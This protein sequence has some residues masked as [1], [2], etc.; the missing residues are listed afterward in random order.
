MSNK[1]LEGFD[2]IEEEIPQAPKK[3]LNK[4]G[5]I[6]I[7]V[8]L[9]LLLGSVA[10]VAIIK[11]RNNTDQVASAYE[12][13]DSSANIG[14]DLTASAQT[15]LTE[16]AVRELEAVTEDT[17]NRIE[18]TRDDY[19][20]QIET[21]A[22]DY[23]EDITALKDQYGQDSESYQNALEALHEDYTQQ[24][25]YVRESANDDF[26]G[27]RDEYNR[28]LED[29]ASSQ[30]K[31][32]SDLQSELDE[33]N[34]AYQEALGALD[35]TTTEANDRLAELTAQNAA[36]IQTLE[37]QNAALQEEIQEMLRRMTSYLTEDMTPF[38]SKVNKNGATI[39]GYTE[40]NGQMRINLSSTQGTL[41]FDDTVTVTGYVVRELDNL[42]VG[43]YRIEYGNGQKGYIKDDDVSEFMVINENPPYNVIIKNDETPIFS[44]YFGDN[45]VAELSQGTECLL[46]GKV[47]RDSTFNGMYRVEYN[48]EVRYVDSSNISAYSVRPFYNYGY[49]NK[50]YVPLYAT[51]NAEAESGYILTEIPA[52][53]YLR[54]DGRVYEMGDPTTI[55]HVTL[56]GAVKD[57]NSPHTATGDTDY[58]ALTTTSGYVRIAG[59]TTVTYTTSSVTNQGPDPVIGKPDS[60][61][62]YY[63]VTNDA[64][65][66]VHDKYDYQ[67]ENSIIRNNVMESTSSTSLGYGRNVTVT[68]RVFFD[69]IPTKILKVESMDGTSYEGLIDEAQTDTAYDLYTISPAPADTFVRSG[70]AS[71]NIMPLYLRD[72]DYRLKN[73]SSDYFMNVSKDSA[74]RVLYEVSY[75]GGNT[76]YAGRRLYFVE[77]LA[78]SRIKGYVDA[79]YTTTSFRVTYAVNNN[80]TSYTAY[81][82]AGEPILSAAPY[83][84]EDDTTG[85]VNDINPDYF[86]DSDVA[87]RDIDSYKVSMNV[88][89]TDY[90]LVGWT[91]TSGDCNLSN[92]VSKT[93]TV[94]GNITVYAV[95]SRPLSVKLC[96]GDFAGEYADFTASNTGAFT[97]DASGEVLWY[98]TTQNI[99]IDHSGAVPHWNGQT[100]S[101]TLPGTAND[102][103]NGAYK[104]AVNPT[105]LVSQVAWKVGVLNSNGIIP[106]RLVSVGT[107]VK[108]A[109]TLYF[110]DYIELHPLYG[111]NVRYNV[112]TAEARDVF[113]C[114]GDSA[115]AEEYTLQ[116]L[117]G[118]SNMTNR[119][120]GGV[121]GYS[122]YGWSF[123]PTPVDFGRLDEA[124]V[125]TKVTADGMVLY[126]VWLKQNPVQF[127]SMGTQTS[128]ISKTARNLRSHPGS[129][130]DNQ[131]ATFYIDA[132]NVKYVKFAW[133]FTQTNSAS[134]HNGHYEGSEWIAPTWHAF[135]NSTGHGYI[136]GTEIASGGINAQDE[137]KTYTRSGTYLYAPA[138]GSSHMEITIS[139]STNLY[140]DGNASAEAKITATVQEIIF[141]DDSDANAYEIPMSMMSPTSSCGW[142]DGQ[143]FSVNAHSGMGGRDITMSTGNIDIS[144]LPYTYDY[145]T[146]SASNGS[147]G[148]SSD[149]G[150]AI[151]YVN[152]AEIGRISPGSSSSY[153][154]RI[155][156]GTTSINVTLRNTCSDN[157]DEWGVWNINSMGGFTLIRES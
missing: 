130:N 127:Y 2:E 112:N 73:T 126:A 116:A 67:L 101:V 103:V 22:N 28:R 91:R 94:N 113:V 18:T 7:A 34:R 87:D 146:F 39:Y 54:I 140:H 35:T 36:T 27:I 107:I 150:T 65:A 124:D 68:G 40:E 105:T 86:T 85:W 81:V 97:P 55:Y 96:A 70:S 152:G 108:N 4:K 57:L 12:Q 51:M 9:L 142:K 11:N 149:L 58:F 154:W 157:G 80:L 29:L 61:H 47:Y 20:N 33:L 1:P 135:S 98:K 155:P 138:N 134:G 141:W 72:K 19:T 143:V 119:T 84:T 78:D 120:L 125:N 106:T 139:A 63:V 71:S 79:A 32:A 83:E 76:D 8:A 64:S 122:F 151:I 74:F 26:S 104:W 153:R 41:D 69:G 6:A 117:L 93:D 21:I 48:G 53:T 118:E 75:N 115:V 23:Q 42:E 88:T 14:T 100:L 121:A 111:F 37:E 131:S 137:T 3:P 44:D 62:E 38:V 60:V 17:I 50:P 15:E 82:G 16:L 147:W 59:I 52:G 148:D 144:G 89:G 136:A 25:I 114:Y 5:M 49:I 95:Y 24:I 66:S 46:T 145:L 128:S 132:D 156:V 99:T 43:Y 110:S 13:T 77:S 129:V 30:G 92:T 123:S 56:I 102:I 10:G 109:E 45:R 31:S 90:T 133:T